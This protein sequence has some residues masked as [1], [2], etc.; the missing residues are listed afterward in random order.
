M[1]IRGL[2]FSLTPSSVVSSPHRNQRDFFW[3]GSQFMSSPYLKLGPQSAVWHGLACAPR[4][5]FCCCPCFSF[6]SSGPWPFFSSFTILCSF[7]PLCICSL[8]NLEHIFLMLFTQG[9]E[10]GNTYPSLG[11]QRTL[12]WDAPFCLL[13]KLGP[14]VLLSCNTLF[15]PP[16]TIC[17]GDFT[18]VWSL[19]FLGVCL[20]LRMSAV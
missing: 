6:L 16:C 17:C 10:Q 20:P 12:S 5:P 3:N 19:V 14:L 1:F 4:P 2:L 8:L 9:N 18:C 11:L 7:L 13:S 15:S